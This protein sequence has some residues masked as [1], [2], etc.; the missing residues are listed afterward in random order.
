MSSRCHWH[1]IISCFIK[2]QNSLTFLV[3]AYPGCPGKEAVKWVPVCLLGMWRSYRKENGG[4]FLTYQW[5]TACFLLYHPVQL[6]K[7]Q[8]HIK[9]ISADLFCDVKRLLSIDD[10]NFSVVLEWA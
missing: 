7:Y 8:P 3:P 6:L 1:P 4:N 5:L 2:I 9:N 10:E